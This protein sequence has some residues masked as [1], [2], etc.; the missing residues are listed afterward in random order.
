MNG[1][2]KKTFVH[3]YVP[4]ELRERIDKLQSRMTIHNIGVRVS[5]S[6]L[7]RRALEIGIE[8]LENEIKKTSNR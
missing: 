7:T 8:K 4:A 6:E 2:K 5:K 1:K 3:I